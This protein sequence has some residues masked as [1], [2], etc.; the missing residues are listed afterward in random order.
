MLVVTSVLLTY[1]GGVVM[2]WLHA[3]Y[4]GEQ[5]PAINDVSHWFL[6]STLGFVA[7]TPVIFFLIASAGRLTRATDRPG[8]R[9]LAFYAV[10]LGTSFALVTAPGPALHNFIAGEGKPLA[11][12]ATDL[13]GHDAAVAARALTA[14][15]RSHV[16]EGVLQ[17]AVGF[18]V[19]IAISWLAAHLAAATRILN[20]NG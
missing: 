11:N 3:I 14:E 2:F 10:L 15:P 19:Y 6:D 18:P 8:Y 13:F 4:R 1:G 17:V 5:G 16:I 20:H 12:W 9:R 7:L